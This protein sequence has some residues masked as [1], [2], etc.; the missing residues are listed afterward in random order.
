MPILRFNSSDNNHND[1]LYAEMIRIAAER[2]ESLSK[3]SYKPKPEP[4]PKPID[5]TMC[6]RCG[7]RPRIK[8][9]CWCRV[10]RNA[11]QR[12]RYTPQE[13]RD[14][15]LMYHY[16]I[17]QEEYDLMLFQQGGVCAICKKPET[18]FDKRIGR[19]RLLAVDHDHENGNVRGLLCGRCNH[20]LGRIET[21]EDWFKAIFKYKKK[22]G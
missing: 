11:Y 15:S 17:T 14:W 20:M 4:K 1:V 6:S 8:R 21:N 7:E 18:T 19:V 3:P 16:G 12:S 2:A 9:H 10:C 5:N 22:H 13:G